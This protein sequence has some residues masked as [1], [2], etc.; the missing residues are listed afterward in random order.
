MV[1]SGTRS[2]HG[3][4]SYL[5]GFALALVLTA[6]PF[7]LVAADPLPR[8][9]TLIIIGCAAV[10]Q[11]LVHL[12]CFLHLDLMSTPHENLFAILFTVVLIVI[13]VGGSFWIMLDLQHRMM[14]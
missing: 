11:I 12:R 3:L 9:V 10:L 8:S 1:R 6:L 5:L 13:M 4:K 14:P 7:A 2:G